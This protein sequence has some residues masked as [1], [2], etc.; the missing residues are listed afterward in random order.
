[1]TF[2]GKIET[3]MRICEVDEAAG[4]VLVKSDEAQ[5]CSPG[6]FMRGQIREIAQRSQGCKTLA[7]SAP[8]EAE[9]SVSEDEEDSTDLQVKSEDELPDSS[10]SQ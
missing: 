6:Q 4:D 10:H 9:E 2:Q 3:L 1:M 7:E 8:A 5:M